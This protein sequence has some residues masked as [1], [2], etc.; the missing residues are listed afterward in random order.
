MR[1]SWEWIKEHA[2]IEAD[3][4]DAA[5]LLSMRG[6]TVDEVVEE[7]GD[8]VLD[9]DI[10]T[11]RPDAMNVRGVA[12]EL[13]AAYGTAVTPL[14]L[15]YGESKTPSADFTSIDIQD[16]EGCHRFCARIIRGV[17]NGPSPEWMIRRLESAGMRSI[18]L[19]VDITNYVLW[20]LGHPLHGYDLALVPDGKIVVRRAKAGERIAMIDGVERTLDPSTLVIADEARAI[21]IGGI[22]GGADTEIN[23]ATTDILLEGAYFDP[24]TI[25]LGSRKLGLGTEASYR[26]ERGADINGMVTAIDRCCHLYQRLAGGKICRGMVDAYPTTHNPVTVSMSH[27]RLCS[28]AGLDIPAERVGQIFELLELPAKRDEDEWRVD[29]PSRRVDLEREADLFEEIIRIVG[30]ENIPFSLPHVDLEPKAKLKLHKVIA[31][32]ENALLSAGYTEAINYDFVD[33]DDNRL[34]APPDAGEPIPLLNPIAAPQ[35]SILRQSLAPSLLH[36]LKFNINRGQTGLRIFEIARCSF[37]MP[38]GPQERTTACFA[39]DAPEPTPF[40]HAP[41][42]PVD[43]FELKGVMEFLF[44]RLGLSGIIISE[45]TAGF[46]DSA[47]RAD[48]SLNGETIGWFGKIAAT[49]KAHFDLPHDV[50]VGQ[51]DLETVVE[52]AFVQRRFRRSSRFPSISR[53]LS[54]ALPEGVNYAKV[55]EAIA[56]VGLEEIVDIKLIDLYRGEASGGKTSLTVRV[57]YQ[58]GER[59]LTQEDVEQS[60]GRVRDSLDSL[61]VE[62]R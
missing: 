16:E 32:A 37:D 6:L 33:P 44:T 60:H 41:Q 40:W 25:R 18:N 26:F 21:G 13:A 49:M 48:V 12:R 10:T 50:F 20:E 31:A 3:P 55:H 59:T 53:D 14:D 51:L 15:S 34:F 43:L 30:Y 56:S 39:A 29:I 45:G 22:M 57:V 52:G 28:F 11:N 42:H 62:F 24:M 61:G 8:A 46:L 23:D 1:F 9:I 19:L 4:S 38:D 54:F 58:S 5:D 36:T 27:R 47:A 7:G 35:W 2:A 17:R